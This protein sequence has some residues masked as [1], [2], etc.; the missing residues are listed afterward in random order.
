MLSNRFISTTSRPGWTDPSS[1]L[2]PI[3]IGILRA[4]PYAPFFAMFL[5][6]EFGLSGGR[7]AP[8]A[9]ALAI[10][11]IIG[12]WTAR[13]V[14]RYIRNSAIANVALVAVGIVCWYVWMWLEPHW[15]VPANPITIANS[16]LLWT[17]V[18][19]IVFWILTLRL[20]LDE[21]EQTSEGVRGIMIRSLI[22]VVAGAALAGFI[23]GDMGEAGLQ[24]AYIGLPAG[25]ISGVGAL[26]MSE[27]AATRALA[28]RRGTTVPGWNRWARSFTGTASILLVI[29]IIAALI[30]GPGFID[31]VVSGLAAVWEAIATVILWIMYGI[32]YVF[33]YVY[34]AIAWFLGL[35]FDE[36]LPNMEV[37]DMGLVGT[38]EPEP[39]TQEEETEPWWFAPYLRFAGIVLLVLIGLAL[40]VRFARA[41]VVPAESDHEEERSSVFSGSLL[42]Q[43]LRNMFHRRSGAEKPRKLDLASDPESVR[44]SMLYLQVLATRLDTPRQPAETPHD[45][46]TRLSGEWPDLG[47]PLAEINHR[48]ERVRYGETDEDRAAVVAAWR[49]IWNA[50][51][52]N[53]ALH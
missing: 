52:D 29:T 50:Q 5:G 1:I 15:D 23:G 21:T 47:E 41:R 12:F 26:G 31:A 9:W 3:F 48:Y 18:I 51:K 20:A 39:I 25:L 4:A 11:S 35:F 24:A 42:R 53:P 22:G 46:A 10:I 49:T 16:E 7:P 33:V 45:F 40:V 36:P 27:M 32:V 38:P 28:R 14:P 8:T 43:Q 17:F 34:K 37:P 19:A 6:E 30:L 13:L 44:E 2:L